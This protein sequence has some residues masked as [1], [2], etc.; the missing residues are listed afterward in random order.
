[1]RVSIIGPLVLAL[2]GM[3]PLSASAGQWSKTYDVSAKPELKA[4]TGDGDVRLD[5]WDQP[6]I[7]AR[8]DFVGYEMGK[9][10]Q[11]VE[12]QTGNRVSIEIRFPTHLGLHVGRRSLTL[13]LKVPR[14][15]ALDLTSGDGNL[16]VTG[17]KGDMRMH[18]GDGRIEAK[19]LD[20]RLVA[21]T[22]DGTIDVDGRFD[23]LDVHTGDGS[24]DAAA[25]PGSAVASA[26][27]VRTG[28][29]S[30]T[31]RLPGDFKANLDA[32]TGD[33]HLTLNLPITMSGSVDRSHVQGTLNG[34]GGLLT[35]RTGD[36]S[37]RIDRY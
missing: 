28:D 12:S 25:S 9:D 37:I 26:W 6:R 13:T 15:S 3:L 19:S 21:S 22:G 30:V 10:F 5:V 14:E 23:V 32:H 35:V 11:V 33:G 4:S 27:S 29:G 36:G 34:G 31:L 7:E 24:V 20:G 8:L 16:A 1:M 18:T 17:V 2:C